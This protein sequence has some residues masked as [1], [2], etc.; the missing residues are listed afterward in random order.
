MSRL[1]NFEISN[2]EALALEQLK[3]AQGLSTESLYRQALMLY[4]LHHYRLKT[5]ETCT[6]SGDEQRMRDFAGPLLIKD[7]GV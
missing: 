5:G 4:Q 6:W 3:A 1:I 2:E 7:K